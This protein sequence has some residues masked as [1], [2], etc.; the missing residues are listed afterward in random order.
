MY[1]LK[2]E[3]SYKMSEKMYDAKMLFLAKCVNNN[4]LKNICIYF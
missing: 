2:K 4:L 1:T 3:N